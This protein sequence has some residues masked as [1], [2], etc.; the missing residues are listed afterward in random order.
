MTSVKNMTE[1]VNEHLDYGANFSAHDLLV[2]A[3]ARLLQALNST[4]ARYSNGDVLNHISWLFVQAHGPIVDPFNLLLSRHGSKSVAQEELPRYCAAQVEASYPMMTSALFA[5][6]RFSLRERQYIS[7]QLK[8]V[9]DSFLLGVANATWL[10]RKSR[11]AATRKITGVKTVLWPPNEFLAQTGLSALYELFPSNETSFSDFWIQTRQA[12]RL[13]RV[14]DPQYNSEPLE[15]PGSY[16]ASFGDVRA[17]P[18]LS[19]RG[20]GGADETSVLHLGHQGDDVRRPRLS[21]RPATFASH[22]QKRRQP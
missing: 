11:K 21:V 12:L 2:F 19:V 22:R 4:F 13:R 8:H 17:R 9:A 18:E 5:V 6:S 7:D 14:Q 20:Y 10:D 3:E 1:L 15:A 16:A